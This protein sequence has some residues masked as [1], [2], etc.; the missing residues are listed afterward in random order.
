MK[1][2]ILLFSAI[3]LFSCSKKESG[4]SQTISD[5]TKIIES[6][7]LERAKINERIRLKN[8]RDHF[9]LSG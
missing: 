9:N 8:N 5:S 4:L 2:F 7:N 3:F 6:L 1:K